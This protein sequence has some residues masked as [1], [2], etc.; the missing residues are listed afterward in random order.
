MKGIKMD[1]Q[2]DE[3]VDGN[4]LDIEWLGQATLAKQYGMEFNRMKKE[5]KHLEEKKKIVRSELIREANEDPQGCCNKAKPNKED[6]E[7]FYRTHKRYQSVVENLIEAQFELDNM[8][9]IKN[10]ICFT[11][12]ATLEHMVILHGQQYFAGPVVPRNLSDCI[13]AKQKEI[14]KAVASK[15]QRKRTK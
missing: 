4:A 8:E 7:A 6:I 2:N 10:E 1:Y 5:V 3:K 11:R 13:A 9:T 14:N 12:K 15:M